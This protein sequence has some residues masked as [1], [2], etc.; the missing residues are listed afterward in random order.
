MKTI[1]SA[2]FITLL[3]TAMVIAHP[4]ETNK[5]LSLRPVNDE[6]QL[7]ARLP[8]HE[9]RVYYHGQ[10]ETVPVLHRH[11]QPPVYTKSD[12]MDEE[13]TMLLAHG[14]PRDSHTVALRQSAIQ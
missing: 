2:I 7:F 9:G 13:D 6:N 1:V 14:P 5:Q 11:P 8:A 10:S 12:P 4:I 3:I